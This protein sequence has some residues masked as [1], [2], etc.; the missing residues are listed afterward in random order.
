[1]NLGNG[2][3]PIAV[4]VPATD[5]AD[6]RTIG[7]EQV[8]KALGDVPMTLSNDEIPSDAALSRSG[9]DGGPIIL[10]V[11]LAML[12]VEGFLAMKFGHYRRM[13]GT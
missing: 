2:V 6:L 5:E 10:L 4:N 11:V 13:V 7:N 3:V 8:R 1:M 12:A 9:N